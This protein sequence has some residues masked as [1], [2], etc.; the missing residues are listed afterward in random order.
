MKTF[1]ELM[2]DSTLAVIFHVAPRLANVLIFIL[3]GRLSG[4]EQAGIFSLATTYL[5]IITAVMLGLDDLLIRQVAR[6]P[7]RARDYFGNFL[8]LRIVLA[9]VVYVVFVLILQNVLHYPVATTVPI[10]ILCLSVVPDSLGFVAQSVMLGHRRF[11]APAVIIGATNMLKMVVGAVV[12]LQGGGLIA[13]AC[14]WLIGSVLAM[15]GLLSVALRQVG[16]LRRAN[17]TNFAPLRTH[18]HAALS[19]CGITT[20]LTLDSQMD[21][22]LLSI[23]RGEAEVGWYNAA[24]TIAF[25]LLTLS[26][27]YRFAIYPLMTRYAQS[28]PDKML[29]L[30]QKSLY[31]MAALS[32]PMVAGIII[33]APQ[34]IS[35][36]FGP[37]FAPTISVLQILI[38]SV[39]FFFMSEPCNRLMLASDRQTKLVVFLSISTSVN[40]IVNLILIPR[41]GANGA[42]FARVCS[43]FV[44]FTLN[45]GYISRKMSSRVTLKS[46]IRPL[47]ATV[48][49]MYV[50]SAMSQ[51]MIVIVIGVGAAMYFLALWLLGGI[52]RRESVRTG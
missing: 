16:G 34:I 32:M 15:I 41:I 31:Y 42:A 14:L 50:I 37:R 25:S 45:Y 26:Q 36:I 21:T 6:E 33:L 20:L 22:V 5:L 9:M 39:L 12:L 38:S 40:I 27:A 23:F 10:V 18:W 3:I 17:W 46:L 49:M 44:Y 7:D 4:P 51:S 48:I 47:M 8:L 11:G 24:T 1:F 52:P 43:S 19:F 2:R 35:L 30:F 29:G 13:V 28:A